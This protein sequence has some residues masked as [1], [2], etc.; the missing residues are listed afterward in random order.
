MVAYLDPGTQKMKPGISWFCFLLYCQQALLKMIAKVLNATAGLHSI[1]WKESTSFLIIP[2]QNWR[3][4]LIGPSWVT[5]LSLNQSWGQEI[6]YSDWPGLGHVFITS[7]GDGCGGQ[8][9]LKHMDNG[10][11]PQS[12]MGTFVLKE[13]DGNVLLERKTDK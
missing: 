12:I 5:C 10:R 6:Q 7:P 4:T 2:V 13:E 9:Y 1:R 8:L 11:E 3:K